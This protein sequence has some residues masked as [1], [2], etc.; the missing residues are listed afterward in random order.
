MPAEARRLAG[1]KED[2]E[3]VEWGVLR[4][5]V[6]A[7]DVVCVSCGTAYGLEFTIVSRLRTA[8]GTC[9]TTS[10]FAAGDVTRAPTRD[11][12]QGAPLIRS[13]RSSKVFPV[14]RFSRSQ[15]TTFPSGNRSGA[16]NSPTARTNTC[17]LSGSCAT[18]AGIVGDTVVVVS[19]PQVILMTNPFVGSADAP[20]SYEH[21]DRGGD[22]HCER[23]FEV[24]HGHSPRCVIASSVIRPSQP[25]SCSVKTHPASVCRAGAAAPTPARRQRLHDPSGRR[26]RLLRDAASTSPQRAAQKRLSRRPRGPRLGA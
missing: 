3:R 24:P 9:S 10:S 12:S 21:D 15:R 4:D 8:A 5:R 23:S 26:L 16:K 14:V 18:A 7:R 20:D 17:V 22:R 13:G 1:A 6:R 11:R 25:E 2:R 19:E